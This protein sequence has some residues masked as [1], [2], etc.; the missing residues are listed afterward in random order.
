METSTTLSVQSPEGARLQVGDFLAGLFG[1]W[2]GPFSHFQ[3]TNITKNFRPKGGFGRTLPESATPTEV[4]LFCLYGSL[5]GLRHQEISLYNFDEC[6]FTKKQ[7]KPLLVDIEAALR[8]SWQDGVW[9]RGLLIQQLA[10]RRDIRFGFA[11]IG[12]P[13]ILGSNWKQDDEVDEKSEPPVRVRNKVCV[14]EFDPIITAMRAVPVPGM[15]F[16]PIPP[17]VPC[18]RCKKEIREGAPRIQGHGF[19]FQHPIHE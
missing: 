5:K 12:T 8:E 2:G 10:N 6:V 13:V 3:A 19:A 14:V 4:F 11:I 16:G 15:T 1:G 9:H 7:A 18:A 17:A